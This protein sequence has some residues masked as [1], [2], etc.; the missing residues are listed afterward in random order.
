MSPTFAY[1]RGKT[2][3]RYYVSSPLQKGGNIRPRPD[4]IRRVSVDVLER[5]LLD[6][7][8]HWYGEGETAFL[9][10]LI[11]PIQ[12]IDLEA[13]HIH[14]TVM[15]GNLPRRLIK[16]LAAHP[17]NT[18]LGLITFALRC[19]VASGRSW[20]ETDRNN[21]KFNKPD[22]VL[23]RGLRKAHRYASAL[24]WDACGSKS[25]QDSTETPR[26][27]YEIRL[28]RLAFLAP[29][30]QNLIIAGKQPAHLTLKQLLAYNI[31]LKWADQ[32]ALFA[33]PA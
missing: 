3:Y 14:L 31:P 19:R 11:R 5:G 27:T 26:S 12:R 4:A 20:V 6:H 29:D 25:C 7:L 30:L 21:P 16:T 8:R 23:I 1:G 13:E 28:T 2:I 22:P 18:T 32:R 10:D 15:R 33:K 24:G 17:T 9:Q